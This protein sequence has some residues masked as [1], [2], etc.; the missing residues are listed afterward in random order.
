MNDSFV[1]IFPHIH[2]DLKHNERRQELASK[3]ECS[4]KRHD[5]MMLSV[6]QDDVL[7]LHS[8]NRTDSSFYDLLN[9]VM[10]KNERSVQN[11]IVQFLTEL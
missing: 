1:F 10:S 9:A 8:C 6:L 5:F 3:S 4:L 11:D 2:H 7:I